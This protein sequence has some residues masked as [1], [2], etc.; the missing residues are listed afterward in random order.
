MFTN[1]KKKVHFKNVGVEDRSGR[2]GRST[3]DDV[4][5]LKTQCVIYA[6]HAFFSPTSHSFR[7]LSVHK[8]DTKRSN[9]DT[10]WT[11]LLSIGR[12]EAS[13]A[14][15]PIG[16]RGRRYLRLQLEPRGRNRSAHAVMQRAP[17][18]P[19]WS[20][21][22]KAPET[23]NTCGKIHTHTHTHTHTRA[24]SL[25]LL[26]SFTAPARLPPSSSLRRDFWRL[27]GSF[28]QR[29]ARLL[30][31]PESIII[32]IIII[33]IIMYS[34]CLQKNLRTLTNMRAAGE[35]QAGIM[36]DCGRG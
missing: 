8:L 2:W 18:R 27:C 16:H 21:I 9:E 33:T 15:H 22:E 30:V 4:V 34:W 26:F 6:Q 14:V 5:A 29:H 12:A 11:R 36:R 28:M 17:R 1:G 20:R 10:S 3:S 13:P 24:W 31:S 23:K 32:I 19:Q 7:R 35:L 25:G